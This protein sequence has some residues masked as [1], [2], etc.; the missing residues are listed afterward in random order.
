MAVAERRNLLVRRR[1]TT[2]N[3]KTLSRFAAL[4]TLLV[5]STSV[6]LVAAHPQAPRQIGIYDLRPESEKPQVI[7]GPQLST[8][9][10]STTQ[11]SLSAAEEQ[12]RREEYEDEWRRRQEAQP[13][14]QEQA[15]RQRIEEELR[16]EEAQRLQQQSDDPTK[17]YYEDVRRY[18]QE[19]QLA[20]PDLFDTDADILR[21]RDE[22]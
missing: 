8:T 1:L 21:L 22:L 16:R 2:T 5:F 12:R 17:K 20:R 11:S 19:T 14:E 6:A 13:T 3:V 15:E 7:R 10:S 18:L 4:I 9:S